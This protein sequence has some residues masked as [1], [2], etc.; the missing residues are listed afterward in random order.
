MLYI[1][2]SFISLLIPSLHC[3]STSDTSRQIPTSCLGLDDGYHYLKLLP[4]DS[5]T[6]Y[7]II[8][9]L[10]H[11]E[12]VVI[13]H[14]IDGDWS[15]YLSSFAKYHYAVVGPVRNDHS[16]WSKWF[17]PEL[18][19]HTNSNIDTTTNSNAYGNFLVS[20]QCDKCLTSDDD[21]SVDYQLHG[22]QSAYYMSALAFGCFNAVR[23][24]PACDM[25]FDSYEC[26]I[27]TWDTS[28]TQISS[29][30]RPSTVTW[31]DAVNDNLKTGICD[32]EIRNSRESVSQSF[33]KCAAEGDS[34][35]NWKPSLGIDGR[36][37]QC[38]KPN[39]SANDLIGNKIDD[40][41]DSDRRFLS[42]PTERL[43]EKI[44]F[45]QKLQTLSMY[46]EEVEP[47]EEV[48]DIHLYQSDF[49]SGTYR[50]TAPGTYVVMEDIEFDFNAPP[51][52]YHSVKSPN[53]V[54]ERYWWPLVEDQ[55]KYPGAG[56]SRDPFFLG[57]CSG[58]VVVRAERSSFNLCF[59]HFGDDIGLVLTSKFDAC[60]G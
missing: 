6:S 25:D 55:E 2:S 30:P 23:G 31:E 24:W 47:V 32:F 52:G 34:N 41:Y 26:K 20:P 21:E 42:T 44:A 18:N 19:Q 9:A 53:D 43:H 8:Y 46:I 27:C 29:S 48:M 17:L 33:S 51:G 38:W 16:N 40:G 14:S 12:Y 10:C 45:V 57:M 35:S 5:T 13:D 49:E 59:C 50:I 58:A 7:P 4:D 56:S 11:N 1:F 39:V 37:C 36:F 3:T 15:S 54:R 28:L 22:D 60:F